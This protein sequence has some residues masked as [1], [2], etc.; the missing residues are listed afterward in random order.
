MKIF[1]A[2]TRLLRPRSVRAKIVALLMLPIVSLMALWSYAAVTTVAAI[3][4]TERAKDVNSELLAPVATFVTA[5]QSERTAAM[6]YAARR[7]ETG[8]DDLRAD[9]Q[10]TDK[11]VTALRAGLSSSSSD[12]ALID[13][14][15]PDRLR[16]LEADFSDLAALRAGTSGSGAR[17]AVSTAYTTYSTV[18]D[19]AFAV[20]GA[21]TSEKG[22][23][24]T[25][26]ARVVLELS[27]VRDAVAREQALLAAATASGAL[28]KEQY[29][30]FVGAV[31]TQRELLRPAVADLKAEHRPAY[32]VLLDSDSYAALVKVEDG[33]TDAG[34]GPVSAAVLKDWD[35]S[36]AAV[37]EGLAAAEENAGT[38]AAAK[39][40]VFGWDTLG[41]SGVAVVLGLAGVLLSLLVS[42]VVG[43]GLIVE[44]LDLRNSAL[45]VA[46]R[47]LPQAMRKLHAGQ[48]VD[49]DAEAPMRRLAGDELAQVG[50][51][52]TAV[53]RAA[54]KAA[55]E[56][57]ELL[58]GI[59]GVYVSLARRSQVLL[60]R[61]LDLLGV[62]EQRRQERQDHAELYDLY[63]VDYLATRMRRHS[64]SLLILS[65]IA[66]GRGW[67]DPIALTDVLRAAVAE[68]EDATRV[69]VWAVPKVSLN[70]GSVADVI[71]LLAELVENAAAF[72]PPSTQV[73]LRAARLRDGILI[74][75]EDSGFGMN[76]EAMAEANRKL[77]SEKVDLLDAKQIGLFVVN[78]LA[79]RQGLRVELRQSTNGGVAAAVFIP[80]HL[81]RD[82]M[83]VHHEPSDEGGAP[84]SAL[85]QQRRR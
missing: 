26:E 48:G 20:T 35:A 6:R 13:T 42:V 49:I 16:T 10:A 8:L 17:D 19:H 75:V 2:T 55:S 58:S 41:A 71:H 31:A 51:A 61:Q 12:A 38:G 21:L 85:I 11:A 39:A 34:A 82:D 73:Q 59:S 25:S 63:R 52:L 69:Q 80:E 54:L 33:V 57:A 1:R 15:L 68:I 23:D 79:E 56:R 5:L 14:G 64:E 72:S 84:A 43:R 65:G 60:H 37:L 62:M 44:L 53:Q 4:D 27:R 40:D 66:P 47:R 30:R 7:T 32:D 22:T 36:S 74:E 83:P 24:A 78:R 9:Q 18:I 70:G 67:R 50:T 77:R 81:I 29:A 3:G 45:E 28:G 76:E 46:G